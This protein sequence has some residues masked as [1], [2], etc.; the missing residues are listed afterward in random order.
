VKLKL[1][2][3]KCEKRLKTLPEGEPD[4]AGYVSVVYVCKLCIKSSVRLECNLR[5]VGQGV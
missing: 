1:K 4:T 2:I 5:F 3:G